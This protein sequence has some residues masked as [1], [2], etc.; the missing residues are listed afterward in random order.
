MGFISLLLNVGLKKLGAGRSPSD[1]LP[2]KRP[3][4]AMMPRL[5]D[6]LAMSI[7]LTILPVA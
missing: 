5:S 1:A 6:K 4:R 7:L 3:S 2:A